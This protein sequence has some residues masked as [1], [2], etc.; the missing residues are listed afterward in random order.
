M[1]SGRF[2]SSEPVWTI[3]QHKKPGL[4]WNL[5]WLRCGSTLP[6]LVEPLSARGNK[7]HKIISHEFRVVQLFRTYSNHSSTQETKPSVDLDRSSEWFNFSEP[8]PNLFEPLSSR[9]NKGHRIISHEFGLVQLFPEPILPNLFE[10][11]SFRGNKVHRTI[12]HEFGVVQLFRTCSNHSSTQETRTAVELD[13]SSGSLIFPNRFEPQSYRGNKVHRIISHEFGV[14][15]PYQT[16][17]NLWAPDGT[18]II[19]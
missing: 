18:R 16:L 17:W 2:N 6:N 12:F 19:G 7:D 5:T 13:M 14:V 8:V 1:S 15:Q 10:P 9:G 11:L 4:W 3:V